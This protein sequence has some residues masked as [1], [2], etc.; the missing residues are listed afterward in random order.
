[1]RPTLQFA[2]REPRVYL[3][4]RRER[5]LAGACTWL[6]LGAIVGLLAWW[7]IRELGVLP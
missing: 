5:L 6:M 7:A 4:P 3:S 2:Q 1:M